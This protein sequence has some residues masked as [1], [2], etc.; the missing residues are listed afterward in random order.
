MSISNRYRLRNKVQ[1]A[2]AE[3]SAQN[4]M[5]LNLSN[6]MYEQKNLIEDQE[7][8]IYELKED[9]DF[10]STN[11][12]FYLD[13]FEITFYCSCEKCCGKNTGITA[14][15]E[16]VQEGVTVAADTTVLPF[17]TV[18]YIEGYGQRIVQDRGGA[19]KGKLLDI[20]VSDHN[21]ALQLG[22]CKKKVWVV[23]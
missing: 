9:I 4:T 16:G 6:V 7:R 3:I 2:D 19:I 5:L 20:Y 22:R 23:M 8:D 13:E 21:T 10:L 15:G 11:A 17:G 1:E 12:I 14:S 18:I